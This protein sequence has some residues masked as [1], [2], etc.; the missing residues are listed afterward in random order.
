MRGWRVRGD[1]RRRV[2]G[3]ERRET[4]GGRIW[5]M[6]SPLAWRGYIFIMLPHSLVCVCVV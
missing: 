6:R 1:E 4:R 3:D 2:W 5:Q